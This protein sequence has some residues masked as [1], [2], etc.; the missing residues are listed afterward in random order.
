MKTYGT[1]GKWEVASLSKNDNR[2]R[3]KAARSRARLQGRMLILE[4]IILM[5]ELAEESHSPTATA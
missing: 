2:R 1:N 4:E 3:A 5:E